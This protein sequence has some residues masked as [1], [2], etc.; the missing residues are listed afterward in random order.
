[1]V[2]LP[3]RNI[4]GKQFLIVNSPR[5]F[6]LPLSS[7]FYDLLSHAKYAKETQKIQSDL[8]SWRMESIEKLTLQVLR[9]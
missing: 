2:S 3:Q 8:S 5:E 1:M 6:S 4:N 9:Q 7:D